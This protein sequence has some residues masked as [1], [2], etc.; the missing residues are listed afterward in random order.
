MA[1]EE[2]EKRLRLFLSLRRSS[3][4]ISQLSP[5]STPLFLHLYF[6]FSLSSQHF[7]QRHL[8]AA[9]ELSRLASR[10]QC[11]IFLLF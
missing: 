4:P 11:S 2:K 7:V 6:S 3:P 5:I 10:Y 1:M 9:L 8:I